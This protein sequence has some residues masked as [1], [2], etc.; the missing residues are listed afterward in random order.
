[1]EPTRRP[2]IRLP[3]TADPSPAPTAA[4][5]ITPDTIRHIVIA[6][7]AACRRHPI[8]GPIFN[9]RV[10]DW[11]THLDRI[12]SFW[13]AAILK[14]GGYAG[15]PLEAHLA[16][17]SLIP[18]HFSI[19]LKLFANTIAAHRPALSPSDAALFMTLAG[20]MA[21][22]MIA[23]GSAPRPQADPAPPRASGRA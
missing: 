3:L 14:Q 7:Y 9:D 11:D 15:R 10:H 5:D 21:N 4:Q 12:Q 8:L 18:E 20:R 1:M 22:R 13:A 16:I 6:F 23:A 2:L 17:P 19:W